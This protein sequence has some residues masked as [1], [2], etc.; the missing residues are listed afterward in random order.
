MPRHS[1]AVRPELELLE[2][3]AM[4]ATLLDVASAITHSAEAESQQ[5]LANYVN[6]LKRAPSQAEINGWVQQIDKGLTYEQ[7][8]AAF[9]SG[10]E[11]LSAHGGAGP[12]W[13]NSLYMDELGRMP[14]PAE[15][16]AWM[17]KLQ[18]GPTDP[19]AVASA[20][21]EGTEHL[22]G[23]VVYDYETFLG[24]APAPAE[25]ANWVQNFQAG[26]HDQD[27]AAGFV[28]SSEF[29]DGRSG[30]D[31]NWWLVNVYVTVLR[32]N[33][34]PA[35]V[36]AWANLL[37]VNNSGNGGVNGSNNSDPGNVDNG[38]NNFDPGNVDN[39]SNT[40]DP[41]N[42]DNGS[43]NSDPGNIDNGSNTSDPGNVDN[44][45]CNCDP[46][47]IDNSSG[48]DGGWIDPTQAN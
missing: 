40:S 12:T 7:V 17:A 19:K 30:S 1:H 36:N 3:R 35:E 9:L 29:F 13:I 20:F 27:V 5:V 24:R 16:N 34:A 4:P 10:P 2:T 38:S 18:G 32:R 8:Q 25:V 33:P 31:V 37:A 15:V 43:N 42:V 28:A 21:A 6:L 48:A 47:N 41:G 11:F 39:G 22:A 45:S 26:A 14:V 23:I 44:G 46:N